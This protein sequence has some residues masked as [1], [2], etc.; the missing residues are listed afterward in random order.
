MAGIGEPQQLINV[1]QGPLVSPA[2]PVGTDAVA[3]MVSAFRQGQI[4]SEDLADHFGLAARAKTQAVTSAAELAQQQA[5]AQK[6]LVAP[7]AELQG[8]K[9]ASELAQTNWGQS[10]LKTAQETMGWFGDSI[11]NYKLP[12]GQTDFQKLSKLARNVW[13]SFRKSTL[14][15]TC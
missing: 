7:L 3:Q 15:R 2:A 8:A 11:A 5:E 13:P 14:G 12:N 6:P 10:S 4:T 1:P 9:T